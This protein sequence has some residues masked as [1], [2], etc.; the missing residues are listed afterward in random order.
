MVEGFKTTYAV[1]SSLGRY[2]R[3][4]SPVLLRVNWKFLAWTQVRDLDSGA[5]AVGINR[6]GLALGEGSYEHPGREATQ[7]Y[8]RHGTL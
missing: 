6:H 2:V 7:H 5:L 8:R 1:V 4:I 3:I